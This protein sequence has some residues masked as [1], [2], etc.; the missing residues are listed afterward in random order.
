MARIT[1]VDDDKDSRNLLQV[2]LRNQQFIVETFSTAE[3]FFADGVLNSDLYIIDIN[4]GGISG[5]EVCEKLKSSPETQPRKVLIISAHPEIEKLSREAC[6]DDYLP[7]PFSQSLLLAKIH[8][9]I[10]R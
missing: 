2:F 9:L 10:P 7:R 6:A 5:I 1:I 3:S 8:G 4:L